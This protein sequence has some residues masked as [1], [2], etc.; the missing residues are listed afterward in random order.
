[1]P[2]NSNYSANVNTTQ[3]GGPGEINNEMNHGSVSGTGFYRKVPVGGGPSRLTESER[4]VAA[5]VA[6]A[7]ME[8]LTQVAHALEPLWA[9][10]PVSG[11]LSLDYHVYRQR[12][13]TP[14]P[15]SSRSH[16]NNNNNNINL[17][18]ESTRDS[19]LVMMDATSL[20]NIFMNVVHTYSLTQTM[21]HLFYK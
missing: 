8:E 15:P 20:V 13:P 10:D 17:K 5:E 21:S 11:I 12:F 3:Q 6:M 9:L 19:A 1:M 2:N 16:I 18:S 7:A 14:S 4:V